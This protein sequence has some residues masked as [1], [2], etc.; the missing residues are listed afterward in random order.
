[1]ASHLAP[2]HSPTPR[3]APSRGPRVWRRLEVHWESKAVSLRRLSEQLDLPLH[4]FV[5]LD[6][7]PAEL[8]D[9]GRALPDVLCVGIPGGRP[10]EMESFVRRH[11]ALDVWRS[12]RGTAEDNLRTQTYR[13][14]AQRKVAQKA[15]RHLPLSA[16]LREL[17]LRVEVRAPM[18]GGEMARV[19]Q[20]TCRTNQMNSTLLRFRSEH[21]IGMWL[22]EGGVACAGAAGDDAAGV[23]GRGLGSIRGQNGF[24]CMRFEFPHL[25]PPGANQSRASPPL[26]PRFVLAAW[27]SDAY[28]QYGL[29]ACALCRLQGGAL[30][31]LHPGLGGGGEDRNA[32]AGAIQISRGAG[33]V[34]ATTDVSATPLHSAAPLRSA[35]PP[36]R[37]V[38]SILVVEA[39]NMSCR[40]LNRGV[41]IQLL[42]R[43][44]HEAARRG[45][46]RVALPL[47]PSSGTRKGNRLMQCFIAR[48]RGVCN[49]QAA[50]EAVTVPAAATNAARPSAF[51]GSTLPFAPP[52]PSASHQ[53]SPST[54][55]E[56]VLI[57]QYGG[58]RGIL[59][60]ATMLAA[61]TLEQ[62]DAASWLD[63]TE[64]ETETGGQVFGAGNAAR[65]A[66]GGACN[67]A[68]LTELPR[69]SNEGDGGAHTDS[70]GAFGLDDSP[71]ESGEAIAQSMA[72]H[73]P[74]RAPVGAVDE[75]KGVAW[76]DL[77]TEIAFR[78]D[79]LAPAELR[80]SDEGGS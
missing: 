43:I 61:P 2:P 31:S 74:V 34:T 58:K 15:A 54:A 59:A 29:V 7:N 25:D 35:S 26:S 30:G 66:A 67:G 72:P 60:D 3:H 37:A 45:A 57:G 63:E 55:D 64:V 50:L 14:N 38:S 12:E 51:L 76:G 1:M 47:I 68:A 48:L 78:T 44:G 75:E 39:L 20:L 6:D 52:P 16:F 9:V 77:L 22:R 33:E 28:G 36:S 11:W 10:A 65:V 21:D 53:L 70:V 5:F 17:Q 56:Q 46:T 8:R 18:A 80:P 13:E 27:V 62:L 73:A 19:A 40:V 4:A 42:R 32:E 79:A 24:Q 69:D 49:Q 23:G 71:E 41:E